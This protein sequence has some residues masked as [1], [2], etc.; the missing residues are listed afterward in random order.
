VD[1]RSLQSESS[2][3]EVLPHCYCHCKWG[4]WQCCLSHIGKYHSFPSIVFQRLHVMAENFPI[5]RLT[6]HVASLVVCSNLCPDT[7]C[8]LTVLSIWPMQVVLLGLGRTHVRRLYTHSMT[9][10][11]LY[12]KPS[13]WTLK[14]QWVCTG[15][16]CPWLQCSPHVC[17]IIMKSCRFW[18]RMM[19]VGCQ[20]GCRDRVSY[21]QLLLHVV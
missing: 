14:E 10:C 4:W 6:C 17:R 16:P 9:R 18:V 2:P 13:L 11:Y 12:R 21:L 3:Q 15:C 7:L 8:S 5:F 20:A 1:A 19:S